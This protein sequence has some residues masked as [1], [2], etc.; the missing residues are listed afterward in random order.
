MYKAFFL[1]ISLTL[2]LGLSAAAQ[3]DP[4]FE[5]GGSGDAGNTWDNAPTS[6]VT[7]TQG[8]NPGRFFIQPPSNTQTATTQQHNY[9]GVLGRL[10]AP[11]LPFSSQTATGMPIAGT[12]I[13]PAN[14]ALQTQ[15]GM[16]GNPILPIT[17]LDSF[18]AQSGY[19]DLIY[20]DEGI[21]DIPPYFVFDES[22]RIERGIWNA[23]LSTGHRSD[24]PEAW[25]WPF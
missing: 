18:V 5:T 25:G 8:N 11:N 19:N 1:A 7:M 16:F 4:R 6:D 10:P 3:G 13:A 2:G 21:D 12:Y 22:H 24:A 23:D 14:L 9:Q 20:G 15:F 17:N